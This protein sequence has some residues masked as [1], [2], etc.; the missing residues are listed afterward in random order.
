MTINM[1]VITT[2]K[3]DEVKVLNHDVISANTPTSI[4]I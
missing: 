1:H 3:F 2:C 4:F